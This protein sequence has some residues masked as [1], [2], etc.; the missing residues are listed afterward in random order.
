[1]HEPI[2]P[3]DVVALFPQMR[4]ELL[5]VLNSLST[6]QWQAPT[7]CAG[8][9][10]K[11]VALHILSDDVAYLSRHRDKDG[12]FLEFNSWEELV[13][14]INAHNALWVEATRR[15]SRKLLVSLLEFTGPQI[16][17][18]FVEQID[19]SETVYVSWASDKPAPM[20][21]QVAREFTEYWM[22][23]QHICEAV[24]IST[25]KTHE[26]LYPV[27][28]AFTHALPRTFQ[29][30]TSPQD[31][32]VKLVIEDIG[33]YHLVCSADRWELYART[34]LSPSAMVIMDSDTTWRLF[35]RGIYGDDAKK[36]AVIEG[37]TMLAD[38]LFNTVAIIA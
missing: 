23:H 36:R 24:G 31:T 9:S 27:L 35:T 33:E 4:N 11:D 1:M 3:L 25:L 38:H 7:A 6:E 2:Q 8:W 14:K 17:A 37:D 19:S 21:L 29:D 32:L 26:F 34:D 30:V 18:Y 13:A 16:N 5:R 10:V 28:T 15:L 22:H 20:W 12:I